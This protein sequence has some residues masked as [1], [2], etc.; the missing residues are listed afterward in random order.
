VGDDES[1]KAVRKYEID[2][3]SIPNPVPHNDGLYKNYRYRIVAMFEKYT[4]DKAAALELMERY[5]KGV[6]GALHIVAPNA[7]SMRMGFAAAAEKF[8]EDV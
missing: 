2:P 7:S 6:L 4:N 3:D 8:L 1:I 5:E